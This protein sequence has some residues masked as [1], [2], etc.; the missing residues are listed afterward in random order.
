M[1]GGS[2]D[3]SSVLFACRQLVGF[4]FYA[5][6]VSPVRVCLR[7]SPGREVANCKANAR[8]PSSKEFQGSLDGTRRFSACP[9]KLD[10]HFVPDI[11][12]FHAI[13]SR[14][15]L[16]FDYS[17]PSL[18]PAGISLRTGY[19]CMHRSNSDF[20][21]QPPRVFYH[22]PALCKD[23]GRGSWIWRR[24][25]LKSG[26]A[27]GKWSERFPGSVNGFLPG[28]LLSFEK[29]MEA[30]SVGNTSPRVSLRIHIYTSNSVRN[31]LLY[32]KILAAF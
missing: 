4:S 15:V 20:D 26:N 16:H 31:A 24:G 25:T 9:G 6:P 32:G 27:R 14:R 17:A 18:T 10:I 19:T 13:E 7:V 11:P 1:E 5:S 21:S 3:T 29:F 8:E 23:S 2:R 30:K 12:I 22:R 28:H